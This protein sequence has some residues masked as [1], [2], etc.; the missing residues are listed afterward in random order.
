MEVGGRVEEV[1]GARKGCVRLVRSR[2]TRLATCTCLCVLAIAKD[3]VAEPSHER[4]DERVDSN[5]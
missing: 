3:S 1:L 5:Y 4:D 2:V